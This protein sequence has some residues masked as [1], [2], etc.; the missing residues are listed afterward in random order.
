M[1]TWLLS[2]ALWACATVGRAEVVTRPI[3]YRHN[4]AA[5]EGTLAY[6]S[7]A[8][9]KRPGV[10]LAHE[11]GGTAAAARQRASQLARLGYVIFAID[12]Y[13]KGVQPKDPRDAAARAGLAGMDRKVLRERVEAG[14]NVLRQQKQT[15]A[16]NL[17]AVGYG[18]GGTAVLELARAGADLEGI[19]CLHGDL[20]TPTPEDAKKIGASV[21]VLVGADD[22]QVTLKQLAAF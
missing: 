21:L 8:T 13:G 14:L 12:L 2:V 6:D 9:T 19:V 15:D 17:A 4:N 11:S 16:N 22:P 7:A 1:R 20:S 3:E 18:V 5:H 10:L